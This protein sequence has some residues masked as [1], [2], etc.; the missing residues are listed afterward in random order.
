MSDLI[1]DKKL[2]ARLYD[3]F[4]ITSKNSSKYWDNYVKS[5]VNEIEVNGL[6]NFGKKFVIT[7]GGFGDVPKLTPRPLARRVFKIP[8][9]YKF[10]EKKYTYYLVNKIKNNFF[11]LLRN[12]KFELSDLLIHLGNKLN[13]KTKPF[14]LIRTVKIKNNLIPHSYTKGAINLD[15]ILKVI[16]FYNLNISFE[17]LY[18]KN[19]M[20]IGGGI[21]SILH[22]FKEH[23]EMNKYNQDSK[24]YLIE[25]FP[26][27][28]LAYKN[29][30]YFNDGDVSINS[31][32][33]K[34]NVI[35]NTSIGSLNYLNISFF[36]NSSSFQEMDINQI[37]EYISFIKTHA[38]KKSYLAC[39]LYPSNK[40]L[41]SDKKVVRVM[42]NHFELLGWDKNY[43]DKY[44]GGIQGILYLYKVK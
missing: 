13:T 20:D 34:L 37:E 8:I 32:N 2:F 24:Y 7:S 38:S 26:V 3:D 16:D 28:Y 31:D 36:F 22:S 40:Q 10:L 29:L 27:S 33:D 21:G 6:K 18:A 14:N 17:D 43:Y 5:I 4:K 1:H 12:D 42:N 35:T 9:I 44:Q 30:L 19:I 39:F 25:Q 23:N 15:I 11:N 41:S